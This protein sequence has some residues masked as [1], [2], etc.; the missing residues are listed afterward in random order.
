MRIRPIHPDELALFAAVG[1]HDHDRDAVQHYLQ[2]LLDQGS[3]H[4]DWC[5][6]LADGA[7]PLGRVAYWARPGTPV[8]SDIVLLELPWDGDYLKLGTHL[9]ADTAQQM[10]AQGATEFAAIVDL[11]PRAP[12]WQRFPEQR[13]VLLTHGGWTLRR[14]TRRF[15]WRTAPVPPAPRRLAFRSIADVGEDRFVEVLERTMRGSLDER[16]QADRIQHGADGAA[17]ALYTLLQSLGYHADW[18]QIGSLA[19][20]APV[21]VV[22]VCGTPVWGTIG[23]IGV[24]PEHRR[25]GWIDPL[26]EQATHTLVGLGAERIE[27]DTDVANTPMAKAF[28][29]GGWHEFGTRREYQLPA[30]TEPAICEHREGT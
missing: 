5:F 26:L 21:G 10:R 13:H 2:R 1:T 30:A 27:A 4:P 6:V 19:D 9:L 15:A 29:R 18:W 11:P 3:T 16:T 8:P 12:Q 25:H 24:V 14:T 20:G 7:R 23:H 28:A 17:L 22:M